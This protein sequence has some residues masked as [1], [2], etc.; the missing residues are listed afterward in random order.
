MRICPPM[1]SDQDA[2]MSRKLKRFTYV[3]A[4]MAA[5]PSLMITAETKKLWMV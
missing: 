4:L 1:V 3:F 5:E 2:A